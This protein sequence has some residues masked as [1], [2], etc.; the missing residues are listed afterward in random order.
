MLSSRRREIRKKKKW[1]LASTIDM[2]AARAIPSQKEAETF[3]TPPQNTMY[4]GEM[5]LH[6]SS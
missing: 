3:Q 1:L 4:D 2:L 5:T 6:A